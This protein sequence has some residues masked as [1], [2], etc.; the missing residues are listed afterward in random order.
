[1][2]SRL[3][4]QLRLL[5]SGAILHLRNVYESGEEVRLSLPWHTG[6]LQ[7]ALEDAEVRVIAY[8]GNG[9]LYAAAS[10]DTELDRIVYSV[11]LDVIERLFQI[12]VELHQ[13]PWEV[14]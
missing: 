9:K 12:L 2:N 3:D 11:R 7:V 10:F 5:L 8:T 14:I 13:H 6:A 4:E 1:M